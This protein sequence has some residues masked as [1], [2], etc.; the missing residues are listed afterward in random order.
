MLARGYEV[1]GTVRN[2]PDGRV[3]L[4]AE[5]QK[6]ELELFLKAIQKSEVGHF[7]KQTDS[8]WGEPENMFSGF[9]ITR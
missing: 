9:E 6:Q 4:V 5:G 1:T 3:E 7:I 8:H 2:M